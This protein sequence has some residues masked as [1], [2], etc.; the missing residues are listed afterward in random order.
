MEN[1]KAENAEIIDEG[2]Q[3]MPIQNTDLVFQQDKA[4]IDTQIATAKQ[5]PRNITK[6]VSNVVAIVSMSSKT[7]EACNYSLPRGNKSISG[8]SVH[9]AKIIAQC[10]GNMRIDAKVVAIEERQIISQAI[11]FDLENNLAIKV[12]VRR[13]IMQNEWEGG[14]RTGKMVRMNDDM[15]TMTGNAANS[16][17]LRNAIFGVI[18]HAVTE[19]GYS[20]AKGLITGDISDEQKLITVRKQIFDNLK[21][22]YEVTEK[23]ACAVVGKATINHITGDDIVVLK[24]IAQAIKDGDTTVEFAFKQ[25]TIAEDKKK[26]QRKKINDAIE[27]EESLKK[28]VD[29]AKSQDELDELYSNAPE[30]LM[31]DEMKTYFLQ[32]KTF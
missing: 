13:S 29:S 8:P 32:K 27:T 2:V 21:D 28:K 10:W 15:I 24:G 19:K 14:K 17:A 3:I 16:I 23:E 6:A 30:A 31:T 1:T 5:Y 22:L 7:A 4:I 12:E 11:A 20:A 18:P 26:S 25:P 9:L